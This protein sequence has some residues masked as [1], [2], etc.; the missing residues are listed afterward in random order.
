MEENVT[1]STE[2]YLKMGFN[3]TKIAGSLAGR[4]INNL[5]MRFKSGIFLVAL[6]G[7]LNDE[8][9]W[10]IASGASRHMTT[11]S[12]QIHTISKGSS[13]HVVEIRDNN[14]Y[15]GP[16]MCI[17]EAIKW[18]KATHQEHPLCLGFEKEFTFHFLF[19]R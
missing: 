13:S 6:T 5:S 16:W 17:I 7:T 10:I 9:A 3:L 8:N 12:G 19:R 2:S 11:E 4:I 18:S 1:L 14:S 15:Q